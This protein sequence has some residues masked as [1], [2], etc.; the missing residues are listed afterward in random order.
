MGGFRFSLEDNKPKEATI[1]QTI[2][3]ME[4]HGFIKKEIG[5]FAI[6]WN[7]NFIVIKYDS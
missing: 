7:S 1:R 2:S 4:K 3:R 5:A 6:I